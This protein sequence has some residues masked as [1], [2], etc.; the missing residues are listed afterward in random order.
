[1][2]TSEARSR[3]EIKSRISMEIAIFNK[4]KKTLFTRKLDLYLRKKLAEL[5]IWS[6]A[7]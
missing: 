4:K 3:W 6:I 5:Y 1:V 7:L 2:I